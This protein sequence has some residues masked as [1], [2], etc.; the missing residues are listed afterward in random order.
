MLSLKLEFPEY[1]IAC[2]VLSG[3]WLAIFHPI[4]PL[5]S[6]GCPG[7]QP[8]SF[9]SIGTLQASELGGLYLSL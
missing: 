9:K 8:V 7:P 5:R 6:V 2:V 1:M 3:V 4:R